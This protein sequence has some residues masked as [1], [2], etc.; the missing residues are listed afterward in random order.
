MFAAATDD[1]RFR[2]FDAKTGKELWT[3]K[4]GGAAQATSMTYQGRDGRQYVVIAVTAADSS[5]IR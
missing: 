5:G 1:A 2:A 3:V 4:L